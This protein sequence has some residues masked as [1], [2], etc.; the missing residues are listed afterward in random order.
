MDTMSLGPMGTQAP[1]E[2][3]RKEGMPGA[4]PDPLP[5]WP[6]GLIWGQK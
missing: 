1:P 6:L 2:L 3:S 4:R 5:G